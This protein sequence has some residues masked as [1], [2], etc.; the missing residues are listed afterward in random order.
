M[1]FSSNFFYQNKHLYKFV[2]SEQES[3][4]LNDKSRRY[5]KPIKISSDCD[6]SL[7]D[8]EIIE[9]NIPIVDITSDISADDTLI[10]NIEGTETE[11]VT[12][13]RETA[14][15]TEDS[16]SDISSRSSKSSSNASNNETNKDESEDESEDESA[17]EGKDEDEDKDNSENNSSYSGSSGSS[18]EINDIMVS[19]KEFP[20]NIITIE[21]CENTL[22]DLLVNDKIDNNELTCVILQI[23][24]ILITYQKLFKFTHNDLHTNNIMYIKTEK[25][26]L[27]YKYNDK[28]YKIPTYGKLFKIIDFGRAIYEYKG[29]VMYSDSFHK[30]GDAA[31]QYNSPPFYNTNKPLI[32][33][34]MS[35]D[36]CR[37][38]CSIYDF[39]IDK[40]DN[41]KNMSPIHKII[42]DWCL[43][44]E[45]KNMLY[46]N[47]NQE[48]YPD[49]KLYKMIARKVHGHLPHKV[50]QQKLF[51]KFMVP[52][53]EIKSGS[54]IMNIDTIS[55]D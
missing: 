29:Q 26:Y 12:K 18:D 44:D 17:D 10:Y 16:C 47:N 46:K 27:Y 22:D 50:L 3:L 36:L 54:L 45:G 25:K 20:V 19:V 31:T 35:F 24:M 52:K 40:Y 21:C 14:K 28:H 51:N 30:D 37:L 6:I 38:G 42:I 13:L 8:I 41:N 23:L 43:D 4:L 32:E 55:L 1:L 48:R 34:N 49:F 7:L 53:K 11:A 15:T 33:P 5:K 9:S 2:N 39:I